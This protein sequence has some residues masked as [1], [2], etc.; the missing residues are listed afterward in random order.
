M[1]A[2]V[3]YGIQDE[4]VLHWYILE[5]LEFDIPRKKTCKHYNPRAD[6]FDYPHCAPF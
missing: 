6:K 4:E 5:F 1:E 3:E 2:L